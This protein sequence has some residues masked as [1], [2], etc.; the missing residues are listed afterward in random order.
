[1]STPR[2]PFGQFKSRMEYILRE[3]DKHLLDFKSLPATGLGGAGA[4]SGQPAAN[5]D[6]TMQKF[7]IEEA[8]ARSQTRQGDGLDLSA[9]VP[10]SP[11]RAPAKPAW[12]AQPAS[13]TAAT[14]TEVTPGELRLDKIEN[15]A[16]AFR[17]RIVGD[18][19]SAFKN[20]VRRIEDVREDMT[21]SLR[22]NSHDMEAQLKLVVANSMEDYG[23]RELDFRQK[24]NSSLTALKREGTQ[25]G[26]DQAVTIDKLVRQVVG[27]E[28]ELKRVQAVAATE[29]GV[30]IAKLA[31]RAETNAQQIQELKSERKQAGTL[32]SD[33][34]GRMQA[35]IDKQATEIRQLQAVQRTKYEELGLSIDEKIQRVLEVQRKR[36][37][38]VNAEIERRLSEMRRKSESEMLETFRDVEMEQVRMNKSF[39]DLHKLLDDNV[40][41][42]DEDQKARDAEQATKWKSVGERIATL[43]T[44]L[45]RVV[46]AAQTFGTQAQEAREMAR[47]V[48]LAREGDARMLSESRSRSLKLASQLEDLKLEVKELRHELRSGAT[49][50]QKQLDTLQRGV[51]LAKTERNRSEER[52]FKELRDHAASV[53]QKFT[54]QH[55][56]FNTLED[57]LKQS[58]REAVSSRSEATAKLTALEHAMKVAGAAERKRTLDAAIGIVRVEVRRELEALDKGRS[59]SLAPLE[60]RLAAAEARATGVQ[61]ALRTALDPLE[62]AVGVLK[63]QGADLTERIE[64]LRRESNQTVRHADAMVGAKIAAARKEAAELVEEVRR[65]VELS[66]NDESA[67]QQQ[68]LLRLKKEVLERVAEVRRASVQAQGGRISV[69][70]QRIESLRQELGESTKQAGGDRE[71]LDSA[72]RMIYTYGVQMFKESDVRVLLRDIS[73][74]L[75]RRVASLE[76]RVGVPAG[77]AASVAADLTQLSHSEAEL[78]GFNEWL[79]KSLNITSQTQF[80]EGALS[81]DGKASGGAGTGGSA[82]RSPVAEILS[83]VMS[84]SPRSSRPSGTATTA[85]ATVP[86]ASRSSGPTSP[87]SQRR[88]GSA[89]NSPRQNDVKTSNPTEDFLKLRNRREWEQQLSQEARRA[90]DIAL[91][92]DSEARRRWMSES[93]AIASEEEALAKRRREI[94]EKR[95]RAAAAARERVESMRSAAAAA[96]QQGAAAGGGDGPADPETIRRKYRENVD[97]QIAQALNERA[98]DRDK[99]QRRV[100]QVNAERAARAAEEAQRL[101]REQAQ[102]ERARAQQEERKRAEEKRARAEEEAQRQREE[103][104]AE[105]RR[106]R[107]NAEADER[108]RR[109]QAAAEERERREQAAAGAAK[110]AVAQSDVTKAGAA[111]TGPV[112]ASAGDNSTDDPLGSMSLNQDSLDLD[113]SDDWDK[114]DEDEPENSGDGGGPQNG[115]GEAKAGTKPRTA[116]PAS[117]GKASPAAGKKK[118]SKGSSGLAYGASDLGL[119]DDG[120]DD[121]D[122]DDRE[123]SPVGQ[124]SDDDLF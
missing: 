20:A 40:A 83:S 22:T 111:A 14:F 93:R 25:Q 81:A 61:K 89:A 30:E 54:E 56:A 49:S 116:A 101:Q 7:E 100:E 119:G 34:A 9:F 76:T 11:E 95:E 32:S 51:D 90:E 99:E 107:E 26:H 53:H 4:G 23:K 123:F 84:P 33:A 38:A 118:K 92:E 47:K 66:Q 108:R 80:P 19:E 104:A 62:V 85:L 70:E 97:A 63:A 112:G 106:A 121:D 96:V 18:L 44:G 120:D 114:T 6:R 46:A 35:L 59:G 41:T 42:A 15:D 109:D 67:A 79:G 17:E 73:E 60:N 45:S 124:S 110:A 122:D 74:K 117:A 2:Q 5:A 28:T 98:R 65:D 24:I 43:E 37:E 105:E 91:D 77:A 13:Q 52:F 102:A 69:V 39:L 12:Y 75:C 10:A 48:E 3:T 88:G 87:S 27:L 21:R 94:S 103:K 58:K 36:Q 78:D 55:T 8:L 16:A 50:R 86:A 113:M 68:R 1:M 57:E 115:Q 31:S 29:G 82:P 71:R 64:S 72:V